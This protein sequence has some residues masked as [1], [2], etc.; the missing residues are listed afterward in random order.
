[1]GA[2]LVALEAFKAW[3]G[4]KKKALGDGSKGFGR[5]LVAPDISNLVI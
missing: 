3:R 1:M 2:P 5:F 4:H